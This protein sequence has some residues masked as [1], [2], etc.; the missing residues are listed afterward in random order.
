MVVVKLP[1]YH[2]MRTTLNGLN[3]KCNEDYI[4]GTGESAAHSRC[5]VLISFPS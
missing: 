4:N 2:F 5:S 3:G 1:F